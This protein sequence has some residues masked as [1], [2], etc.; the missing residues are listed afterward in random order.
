MLVVQE[1]LYAGVDRYAGGG[2]RRERGNNLG[3]AHGRFLYPQLA[4]RVGCQQLRQKYDDATGLAC[5]V[6]VVVAP[7]AKQHAG[8]EGEG[9]ARRVLK[10][11]ARLAQVLRQQQSSSYRLIFAESHGEVL[12]V[13]GYRISEC[14]AWGRFLYVDDLVTRATDQ[15]SGFGGTL[16]D[17]LVEHAVDQKCVQLHLDSGV[18]RFVAHRFYLRK[19]MDLTSHHFS[20]RLVADVH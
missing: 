13:A 18:H 1:S 6:D 17:W 19:R 11:L 20:L 2:R 3:D 4:V 8:D 15:A 9:D 5:A 10:Y 14:L 12:A 7:A 16:F